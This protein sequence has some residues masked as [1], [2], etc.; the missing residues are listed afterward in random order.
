MVNM[1]KEAYSLRRWFFW[2]LVITFLWLLISKMTEIEKLIATLSRGQPLGI[3][4]AALLTGVYFIFF[5]WLY[6]RSFYTVEIN[7][8][9]IDL[10]PIMFAALFANTTIPSRGA[11]GIALFVDNAAQHG[12]SKGRVAAGALLTH[13]LDFATF[14]VILIIGMIYLF[15][16]HDLKAYEVLAAV[17]LI[18]SMSGLS[19]LLVLG[20]VRPD[21]VSRLLNWIQNS[22]D[23]LA[24]SIG[25]KPFLADGWADRYS[26]E[27]IEASLAIAT[28]PDRLLA[29]IGVGLA[30]HLVKLSVLAATFYA[31][32]QPFNPG[33]WVAAYSMGIL[34]GVITIT[35]EGIGVVE[36]MMT[37]VLTSLHVPV[38]RAAVISISFRGL[39][40]WLPLLIGF[41]IL[42]K[43]QTFKSQRRGI[44]GETSV[45]IAALLTGFM[46]LINFLSAVTPSVFNRMALLAEIS[47]LEIRRGSHFTAVLAG[48]ALFLLAGSLWRRKR[49]AWLLTLI[50]LGISILSH[51]LKGPNVAPA[52]AA[53]LIMGWLI[54]LRP[55]FHARSDTPSVR[56][57]ITALAAA[58][59]FTLLYGSFGFYLLD[60][61]F[62]VHFGLW[63]A[64]QQTVIM[65][66]QVYNPCLQPLTGFG[67]YFADS[68]YAVG[69]FTSAYALVMLI[70]PVLIR[71]P[72]NPAQRVRAK[73]IVERYGKSP[74]ALLTLLD[75]KQYFFSPGGSVIAFV[76]KG[77]VAITLGDPI[78]PT[79]DVRQAVKG[80]S[81][82]CQSNDWL[83][84]FYQVLPD[85]LP[86]YQLEGFQSLPVGQEA[87]VNLASFSLQGRAN[88]GLRSGVNHALHLGYRAEVLPAPVNDKVLQ[89]L[90]EISDEW[91]TEQGSTEMR[92]S[93]GWFDSTYL[94]SCPILVIYSPDQRITAFANII[95]EYQRPEVSI[96]M[97]RHRSHLEH[98]IMD[99]LF[100]SLFEW[101]QQAG[102]QSVSLGL[103]GLA[104]IGQNPSDPA[105]ERALH[106][107]YEH[108]NVFY[109]F[110]GLHGFKEKFNPGWENRYLIYSNSAALPAVTLAMIKA[111]A[112]ENL[113]G[114]ILHR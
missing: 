110:K 97:M 87:V 69:A 31:F 67:R 109:N 61:H 17:L 50:F 100:I 51:L 80:F 32:H 103:S 45:R 44:R 57:G 95:T 29:A 66:T 70:R 92:F 23:C 82:L 39:V 3:I 77:R 78:G 47:P 20:L 83:P 79:D 2:I 36:G 4:F 49:A 93:V 74:L 91:L 58:F 112:S 46:G 90:H 13:I 56:Q 105:I 10:L 106:Y 12:E 30:S 42:P 8:R 25:Q 113:L 55:Q 18:T 38:E 107:L 26:I 104:G 84:A 5:A 60:R 43:L 22:L 11:S 1:K 96:D 14:S 53:V 99:L 98:G 62:K 114:S 15:I 28:H 71:Q 19:G 27:F 111:D 6:Q 7:S 34:F 64:L 73:E 86:I 94:C 48:F 81:S 35:P 102:F 16:N 68:I 101:A 21:L 59:S 63:D 88:K 75:D 54:Y 72:A 65:F 9:L 108:V 85:Y 37:L 40:F 76:V 89:E 52:A 41:F 33:Q 24:H